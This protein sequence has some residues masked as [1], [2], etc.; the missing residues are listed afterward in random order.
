MDNYN[1]NNEKFI[2]TANEHDK[3]AK[4][5]SKGIDDI[6]KIAFA[7]EWNETKRQQFINFLDFCDYL[8]VEYESF[9]TS[10][11]DQAILENYLPPLNPKDF[12]DI[13]QDLPIYDAE[14]MQFLKAT[15]Q[16]TLST[17]IKKD[18]NFSKLLLFS[19]DDIQTLLQISFDLIQNLPPNY[20][21]NFLK[22][23]SNLKTK[24]PNKTFTPKELN[25]LITLI[26]NKITV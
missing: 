4:C 22:I 13:L 12:D 23:L 25:N 10:H 9:D 15:L 6:D 3:I 5:F 24:N 1:T 26:A 7:L 14:Y 19:F 11:I 20:A 8:Y 16:D 2:I 17:I 18:I 21:K